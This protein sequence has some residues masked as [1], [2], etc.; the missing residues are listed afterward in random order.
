MPDKVRKDL[1]SRNDIGIE[2]Y[3]DLVTQRIISGAV[4]LWAPVK[5]ARLQMWKC[6]AKK[7]RVTS[8]NKSVELQEDRS[9]FARMVVF[10]RARPGINSK[11]AVGKHEFSVVPQSLFPAD[12]SMLHSPKSSLM[13]SLKIFQTIHSK[14]QH[15]NQCNLNH[16]TELQLWMQWLSYRCWKSQSG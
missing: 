5:K 13:K 6:S 2:M 8:G 15:K 14:Q 7:M 9:L 4:N 1:C 10:S 3:E 11:E 16:H 12:G